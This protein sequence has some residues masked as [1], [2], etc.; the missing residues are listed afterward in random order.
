M[1]PEV[2]PK[3][4]SKASDIQFPAQRE[5]AKM[6]AR[7]IIFTLPPRT[8]QHPRAYHYSAVV[9]CIRVASNREHAL[10]SNPFYLL[11]PLLFPARRQDRDRSK[12]RLG[13]VRNCHASV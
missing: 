6:T 9:G 5:I 10:M 8:D 13:S 3:E 11:S 4:L 1:A 12:Q 7:E 2:R